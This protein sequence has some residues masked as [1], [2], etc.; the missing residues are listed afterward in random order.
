MRGVARKDFDLV[1]AWAVDRLGRS[2]PDLVN[3][4]GELQAR[5]VEGAV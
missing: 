1:A 4:L 2:L 5:P 3:L